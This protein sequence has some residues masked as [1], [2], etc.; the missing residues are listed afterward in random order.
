MRVSR[1]V[2]PCL[3][4]VF[5]GMLL[6]HTARAATRTWTGA[7][8]DDNWSTAANWGGVAPSAGDDLVFPGGTPR[9][10]PNNDFA[11]NTS[12]NTISFTGASGGYTLL[13]NAIQLVAGIAATNT[14][15]NS[16]VQLPVT[17]TASQ[18]F[19]CSIPGP[20][21]RLIISGG[22][23]LGAFT[24]TYDV[25]SGSIINQ[26]GVV[27]G[28]G[29]VTSSGTGVVFV[30]AACTYTGPTDITNGD[31]VLAGSSLAPASVVTVSGGLLQFANGASAGPVNATGGFV[32][33]QGG[34]TSQIGNVTDLSL[35]SGSTLFMAM[36]SATNYGQLNA[37]GTVAVGGST[38]LLAWNFTSAT[39][40]AF[41]IIN[42]TSGGAVAGTFTGLPEGAT[43]SQNGRSYQITY[44]GGDG[45]NV[46]VTDLGPAVGPTPTPTLPPP[47]T[48]TPGP[49]AAVP[50]LSPIV[51]AV[52][53][54]A[55]LLTALFAIRRNG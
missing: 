39:G 18:T 11:A 54:L 47:P 1:R 26:N 16:T 3:G 40:N 19:S 6:F 35:Q 8:A 22:V 52:F 17:L 21:D 30:V 42:K 5:V 55:L 34:G 38:L 29:G 4:L 12:F 32:S 53:G 31:F 13:G 46:V 28:T 25:A 41:T 2:R 7:G 14:A 33:C 23:A 9:L 45:N 37:S 15:G 27:S 20:S 43:F 49:T 51:L 50:T 48:P 24:L 36:Y 44:A 10:S